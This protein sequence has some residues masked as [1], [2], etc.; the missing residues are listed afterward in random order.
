[1]SRRAPSR[2][3]LRLRRGFT[4]IELLVVIAII[5]IL[6]GLL[7]PAVQKAMAT[8]DQML[9]TE[10]L[11]V[12]GAALHGY[13]ERTSELDTELTRLIQSSEGTIDPET[14]SSL[15]RQYQ[16]LTADFDALLD[17]M[18]MAGRGKL[19][20]GDRKLLQAGIN[21]ASELRGGTNIIAVL[22]GLL[23]AKGNPT[24]ETTTRLQL[25]LQK[26]KLVQV[27]SH[28]PQ[29]ISDSLRSRSSP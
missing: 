24:P 19:S 17:D 26:L 7:L 16:T 9:K 18:H 6:I 5:A 10:N 20:Q 8:A 11:T 12:I 29:V 14:A 27:T 4:L 1:M 28:L 22:I 21:S 13:S 2:R 23:R 25:E 15:Q 3:A